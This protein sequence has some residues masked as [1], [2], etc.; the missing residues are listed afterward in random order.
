[1]QHFSLYFIFHNNTEIESTAG[2]TVKDEKESPSLGQT[3]TV[4]YLLQFLIFKPS[5]SFS[6]SFCAKHVQNKIESA[7]NPRTE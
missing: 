5:N 2:P 6:F 1:M 4:G 3:Y 7:A